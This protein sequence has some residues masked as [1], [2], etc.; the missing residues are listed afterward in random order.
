LLNTT[1]SGTALIN[2]LPL[3]ESRKPHCP[4]Q[5]SLSARKRL[6]LAARGHCEGCAGKSI[7]TGSST[8]V[9]SLNTG[10]SETPPVKSRQTYNIRDHSVK[11]EKKRKSITNKQNNP[12][13]INLFLLAL[14]ICL[15]DFKFPGMTHLYKVRVPSKAYSQRLIPM[16]TWIGGM[17][18]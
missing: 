3:N 2:S 13:S 5:Y 9:V 4:L 15:T 16:K 11:K 6:E 7:Q 14:K 10:H 17:K 12:L 8:I 18:A 1:A